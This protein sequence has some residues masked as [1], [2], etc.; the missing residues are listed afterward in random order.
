[1]AQMEQEFPSFLVESYVQ[2]KLLICTWKH[3]GFAFCFSTNTFLA[4]VRK[5]LREQTGSSK[6]LL[7]EVSVGRG[8]GQGY[9]GLHQQ[10]CFL[11]SCERSVPW[12]SVQVCPHPS[13][14]T[15]FL[16]YPE[17]TAPA[18]PWP[19][20]NRRLTPLRGFGWCHFYFWE[21][22]LLCR[23]PQ[24]TFNFWVPSPWSLPARNC[25]KQNCG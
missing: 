8:G 1:M 16:D 18:C 11:D 15:G 10:K 3:T 22:V 12:I 13:H 20:V 5:I 4:Y 14:L 25:M 6:G 19:P 9:W 7:Q 24:A 17:S 21:G 2:E 23:I